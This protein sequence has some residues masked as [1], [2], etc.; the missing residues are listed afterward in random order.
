MNLS[1]NLGAFAA[2]RPLIRLQLSEDTLMSELRDIIPAEVPNPPTHGNQGPHVTSASP[3]WVTVIR[4]RL[5]GPGGLYNFGNIIALASGLT[6]QLMSAHQAVTVY[7][8]VRA[9][10]IGSPGA[11]WLTVAILVFFMSGEVYHRAWSGKVPNV[12]LVRAG[13]GLSAL[14]AAALTVSLSYFGDQFL[15]I[16]AGTLLFGGKFGNAV[17]PSGAWW[18]NVPV[19][20][21]ASTAHAIRFDVLRVAVVLSRFPSLA[22]LGAEIAH[23]RLD[24]APLSNSVLLVIMFLCFLI[25][26]RADLMLLDLGQ[27]ERR[28]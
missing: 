3:R 1:S 27:Q 15:A 8:A 23:H 22:A 7:D 19:P 21:R 12:R 6:L 9:Y 25:W 16:V 28:Q 26:L 20:P 13:D 14:G 10:L 18:V 2:D 24:A 4:A 17:A 5:T 11:T